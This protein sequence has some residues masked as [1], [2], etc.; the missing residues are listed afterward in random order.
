[1][2]TQLAVALLSV[3]AF[4]SCKKEVSESLDLPLVEEELVIDTIKTIC[5]Q[6]IIKKDTINLSLYFEENQDIKGELAYLFFEKDKNDGTIVGQMIGDTL[7]ANYTFTSEGKESNRE[8]VF[9]RKGKIM[10][11]AYGDVEEIE[12]KTVFKNPKKLYFDSAT[13]L[14][15]I[16]CQKNVK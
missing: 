13:V 5:Y 3:F 12:S 15:E 7:K 11:E 6:G 2:K 8:I 10:I 4:S 9:L 14:S 1:M 16:D